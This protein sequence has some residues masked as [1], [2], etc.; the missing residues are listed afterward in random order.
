MSSFA[1]FIC[2]PM[3]WEQLHTN[4]PKYWQ[5]YFYPITLDCIDLKLCVLTPG[6]FS[7]QI[8]SSL[9]TLIRL[10]TYTTLILTPDM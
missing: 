9:C 10:Q 8:Y 7:R 1:D 5:D 6:S 2:H 4:I 3:Q